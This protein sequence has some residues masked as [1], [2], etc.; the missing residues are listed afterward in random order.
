[1]RHT[2]VGRLIAK[3]ESHIRHLFVSYIGTHG[4]HFGWL[5]FSILL[6]RF[7]EFFFCF[8]LVFFDFNCLHDLN[9]LKLVSGILITQLLYL[10]LIVLTLP[11]ELIYS[12]LQLLVDFLR[13]LEALN[14]FWQLFVPGG[15]PQVRK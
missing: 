3:K 7:F 2:V 1:M 15:S 12:F 5:L 11:N 8:Y 10:Q 6:R 14:Y 4:S 13:I 9:I